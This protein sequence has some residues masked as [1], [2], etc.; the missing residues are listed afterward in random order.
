MPVT[1]KEIE[2]ISDLVA[3]KVTTRLEV[4]IASQTASCL[5][6]NWK[7]DEMRVDM[8]G[9]DGKSGVKEITHDNQRDIAAVKKLSFATF[10]AVAATIAGWIWD[11]MTS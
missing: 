5:A 7:T 6:H 1:Q 9:K 3:L 8:Y 2:A 10:G 4:F 11:R